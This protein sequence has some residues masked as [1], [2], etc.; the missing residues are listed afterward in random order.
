MPTGKIGS[1]AVLGTL[2]ALMVLMATSA[3]AYPPGWR[4]YRHGF[5]PRGFYAWHNGFWRHS[6]YGGRFGWWW[7]VGGVWYFY[8]QP[9]YPYPDP[10]VPPNYPAAAPA[11]TGDAPPQYW[12][13]CDASKTYYPYVSSCA[14][15]WRQVPTTPAPDASKPP[16]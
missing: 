9:V 3:Q 12:Y 1:S 4:G 8:P 16:G 5:Y 13:Y 2:C 7:V 14:S 10:Y 15:G 11:P 6:W